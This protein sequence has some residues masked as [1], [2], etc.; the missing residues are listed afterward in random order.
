MHHFWQTLPGY[1][2]FPDFYRWLAWEEA[3]ELLVEVGVYAGQSAAFYATELFNLLS[4]DTP[5]RLDLV[6][7]WTANPGGLDAVR[8][9]LEPVAG[10]IG[11]YHQGISWEMAARYGEHSVDA[12]FID[13]DHEYESVCK[14]IDA[15]LPKVKPG[16]IIAGHDY[17]PELPGVIRAV[18]ERFER[19]ELWRGVNDVGDE[20]MRGK[21]YPVWCVRI[22]I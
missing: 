6:D 11:A 9:A 22:P 5:C 7:T 15:W 17:T 13:A 4:A 21:Y 18:N 10:V 16:G 14:D 1:F 3:P 20:T 19:F 8:K 2:T 12:V